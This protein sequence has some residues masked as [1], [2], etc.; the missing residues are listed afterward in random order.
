MVAAADAAGK[1]R[2]S[3]LGLTPA[4][5]GDRIA[6]KTFGRVI[7]GSVDPP[8]L[9]LVIRRGGEN[10][11]DKGDRQ[12]KIRLVEQVGRGCQRRHSLIQHRPKVAPPPMPRPPP[13][14]P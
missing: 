1:G 2:D 3:A 14:R 11:D 6:E 10:A 4:G 13:P 7:P 9:G 12:P 5:W 8:A